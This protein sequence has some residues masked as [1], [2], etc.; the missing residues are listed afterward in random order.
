MKSGI[1]RPLKA[2][3]ALLGMAAVAGPCA[4]LRVSNGPAAARQANRPKAHETNRIKAEMPIQTAGEGVAFFSGT[5]NS[6]GQLEFLLDTG[7]AGSSLEREVADRLG[8][9]IERG[10]ASVAGNA[11]LEV[12]V[13]PSA[14]IGVQTTSFTA[15][16]L[17][18]AALRPL[19]PFFGRRIDGILGGDWMAQH[20]V[21]LDYEKG[22]MRLY[23]PT[24]FRY[25]GRGERLPLAVVRGIPFVDL[26]VTLPN[27]KSLWGHFLVDSGGGGMAVHVYMKVAASSGLAEGLSRIEETGHGIGGAT[28]RF[29]V[30]GAEVEIG[31]YRL[32][33]PVVIVTQAE[34]GLR[35]DP[36]SSGLVGMDLLRRFKVTFDYSRGRMYLEPNRRL[37]DPFVYNTT[38][39][40]LRA[41]PPRFSK[42]T[43]S[44]VREGSPAKEAGLEPGD[45]LRQID[46]HDV[47]EMTIEAIRGTL[48]TA[49]Q[50]HK[51]TVSRGGKLLEVTL[52]TREMLP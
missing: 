17:M 45:E 5:V 36:T 20:V 42:F 21:E 27:G 41:A 33:K 25:E 19:E 40:G 49:G 16:N 10:Q 39:M 46:G 12:G 51:L 11:A 8:V 23:D 30:R 35:A 6:T 18:V 14:T 9:R 1:K 26:K 44:S 3:W 34:G 52:H 31:K 29:A 7:G 4:G 22:L 38:G 15:E 43:V 50:T 48:R 28:A 13:I 32:K 24:E 2:S 37:H 47:S